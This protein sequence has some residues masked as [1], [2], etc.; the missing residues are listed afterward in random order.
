M[1]NVEILWFVFGRGRSLFSRRSRFSGPHRVGRTQIRH[2]EGKKQKVLY[3]FRIGVHPG[4]GH[5][6]RGSFRVRQF[7]WLEVPC[8][9]GWEDWVL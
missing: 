4:H 1:L 2:V 8:E 3:Y 7:C 6:E 9:H 5:K